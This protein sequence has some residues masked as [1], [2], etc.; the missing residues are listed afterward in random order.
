MK[1]T[2]ICGFTLIEVLLSI[3]LMALISGILFASFFLPLRA[4]GA[5]KSELVKIEEAAV[6]L[7]RLSEELAAAY[8]EAKI[9]SGGRDSL[10]FLSAAGTD[11]GLEKVGYTVKKDVSEEAVTVYREAGLPWEAA[12][13]EKP[14]LQ[15][16]SLVFGYYN[17]VEWSEEWNEK[18]L[19]LLVSVT[20]SRKGKTFRVFCGLRTGV[21]PD[22]DTGSDTSPGG[23]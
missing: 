14:V 19:P 22:A 4:V 6:F 20:L 17:G 11:L 2:A 16:E 10:F 15:A 3:F 8:P 18:S 7:A 13:G 12:V 23:G 9:F 21:N 1:R 5:A